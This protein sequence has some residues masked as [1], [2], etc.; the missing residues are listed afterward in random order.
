MAKPIDF[1][2]RFTKYAETWV[3]EQLKAGK[4]PEE[5]E[6]QMPEL[7]MRFVNQ[8]AHWLDGVAPAMYFA[9]W[10]DA[11]TL[12]EMLRE[13]ENEQVAVPDLLLERIT[14]LGD[15]SVAPL[16]ELV[17]DESAQRSLRLT[18]VNLLI[19]LDTSKPMNLCVQLV[20]ERETE[21]DIA[22]AAADL[23]RNLGMEAVDAMLEAL[24]GAS[25][26]AADTF[27]DLL[28]NFKGIER[29]YEETVSRF[30]RDAEHRALHASFLAKLGDARAIELL[31]RASELTDLNYLDYIEIRDAIEALGGALTTEREFAGDPYY[32]SMKRLEG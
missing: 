13:Y 28:C 18:A 6:E 16:M 1:D 21:D 7:Y 3:R 17:A 32:E 2:A 15:K 26:Q 9:Q 19:E 10:D 29:V 12:L 27:L 30:L 4:K 24:E 8:P 5:L 25:D 22:D 20:R 14:D 11:Q 23:L 31:T